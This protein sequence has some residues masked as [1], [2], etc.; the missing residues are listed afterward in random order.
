M[1]KLWFAGAALAAGGV[2]L[3]G[4]TPA[5]A[6]LLP[7][8]DIAQQQADQQ[9]AGLLGQSNGITLENP[10]RHSSLQGAPAASN[11][12]MQVKAGQNSP[13]LN[14]LLPG[15]ST[16]SNGKPRPPLPDADVVRN[17]SGLQQLPLQQLP[18]QQFPG[19]LAGQF[20]GQQGFGQQGFGQQ[21]PIGGLP[22]SSL[23]G[24]GFPLLGGLSPDGRQPSVPQ[25]PTTRQTEVFG[26]G[27][28]LLGGLG[29]LLPVNS[30]QDNP[31]RPGAASRPDTAGLPAG[32]RT[33]LPADADQPPAT[34]TPAP[35]VSA[36]TLPAPADD[37]APA[38]DRSAPADK[39]TPD[40]TPDDPRLHEEPIEDDSENREF[41]PD[42]RPVAGDDPDFD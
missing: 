5:R 20:N 19:Q 42:S 30:L 3:F 15:E 4:A 24:A 23:F 38:A 40:A 13:D 33:V 8:A 39:P 12:V 18:L 32:G 1:R 9:L 28:P 22:L 21:L 26:G 36:S 37:P 2:F 10:L 41:S 25:H 6:D 7:G 14:P 34:T 29:G 16:E 17:G 31:V 35:A 27:V 11:P